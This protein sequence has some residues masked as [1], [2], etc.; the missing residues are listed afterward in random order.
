MK[1]LDFEQTQELMSM[2]TEGWL[3][4]GWSLTHQPKLTPEEA[5]SV[6]YFLQEYLRVIPDHFEQCC[7]CKE[8]YDAGC[9]GYSIDGTDDPDE[10]HT[11]LG[12]TQGMLEENDGAGF[13]SAN[14]ESDFWYQVK[15]NKNGL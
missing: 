11:D 4:E 14:C 10:F 5:F 7:I 15:E 8:L 1:M 13:C 6:I 2:L 9:E 12:V 3:P